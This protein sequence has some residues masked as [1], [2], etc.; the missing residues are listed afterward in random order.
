V[1]FDTQ[2]GE[3][4]ARSFPALKKGGILV[5]I[6]QPP[7]QEE[8]A[9]HGVRAEI[10]RN[11]MNPRALEYIGGL[12]AAGKL[13]VEI[14]EVLPLSETARAQETLKAGHTRGKIVLRTE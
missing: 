14:A 12:A 5:S 7:S 4:Q 6:V 10:M 9:K 1:V 11:T 8:A 13:R 2:G 3:T